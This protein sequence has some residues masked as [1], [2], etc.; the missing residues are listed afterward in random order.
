MKKVLALFL[1]VAMAFGAMAGCTQPNNDDV[2]NTKAPVSEPTISSE[3]QPIVDPNKEYTINFWHGETDDSRIAGMQE[4][5]DGFKMIYPNVTITQTAVNNAEFFTK[6]VAAL[7]SGTAPD[8]AATTPERTM[9]YRNL[10][11]G[12]ALDDVVGEIDATEK[13]ASENPKSL[14]YFD[15]HYWAVPV[16]AITIMLFY[17]ADLFEANGLTP[18]TTWDE[19]LN[20]AKTLTKDGAYGIGLPASS[21]QNC[22]D[23]VAWSFL[24]TNKADVFNDKGEIVFNSKE[25]VETY[26]F[27][28]ELA[29]FSPEDC[30]GWG[31]AETK[32]SFTSGSCA[33]NFM[34]GSSLADLAK[35]DFSDSVGAV[36][37]PKPKNGTYGGNTHTEGLMIFSDDPAIQ[38]I[39]KDFILYFMSAEMYGKA[40]SNMEPGLMLP[41]TETGMQSD[42]FFNQEINAKYANIIKAELEQVKTGSLYGF[43][44]PV[45]SA[46][47]GEIGVSYLLGGTLERVV[48]GT[49]SPADAVAW[50][51]EQMIALCE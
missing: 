3:E 21:G 14:Y 51:E 41:I 23:Q 48:S 28:Q 16:W 22:T 25:T 4:V 12:I 40:L 39:C 17:R 31:W 7:A 10:G 11:Y 1:A 18:P 6:M 38:Q 20:A 47:A 30:T 27:L 43:K 5:I 34:F 15:E 49:M 44:Y 9:A 26:E 19:L 24:S 13:Y 46:Y 45:R 36:S 35:T 8:I 37:I 32:L 42:D 2:E 33:M 50:G 29:Q